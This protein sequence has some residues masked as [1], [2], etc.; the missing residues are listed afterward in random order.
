MPKNKKGSI[1]M[2]IKII[3]KPT[4]KIVP[5]ENNPRL[6][7]EAVEPVANSIKQ[8]GFKVPIIIDSSNIIVAGHT[9]LK[10]AKQ[11]GMDKV[12]C[13]VADDLTEEQIRAFRLV[14]NKVSELADWDYEKLEEELANINSIDMNIFDFDMSEINDIVEHLDED[15]VCDSELEKVSLSEKFLFTPTSVLNTRC[16]YK[17][18]L[19][20]R[21]EAKTDI[22]P[23]IKLFNNKS[24]EIAKKYNMKPK[25]ITFAGFIR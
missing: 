7:D 6:N 17:K 5:Y 10:A 19:I 12:P 8:F 15:I 24:M 22:E 4:D 18:G 11:L 20:T 21:A 3:Y 9:R 14:D 25:K 2:D 23:Y 1:V 16:A 13:I